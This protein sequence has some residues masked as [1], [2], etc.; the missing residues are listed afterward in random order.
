MLLPLRMRRTRKTHAARFAS[1][2]QWSLRRWD[3]Y[4][5]ATLSSC[6]GCVDA[7]MAADAVRTDLGS[8]AWEAVCLAALLAAVG[9]V[10]RNVID[11]RSQADRPRLAAASSPPRP[12]AVCPPTVLPWIAV[13]RHMPNI[14]RI[15]HP[16]ACSHCWITH[17]WQRA[18][19]QYF[20]KCREGRTGLPS[21]RAR[22]CYL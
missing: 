1:L 22:S 4:I 17:R 6:F 14:K 7:S 3:T 5:G 8:G 9:P 19:V 16:A 11:V 20:C 18:A 13:L 10:E 12:P 2:V 21:L 15:R